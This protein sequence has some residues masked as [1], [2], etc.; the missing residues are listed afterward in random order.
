MKTLPSGAIIMDLE[1]NKPEYVNQVNEKTLEA[2][3]K[4]L[5]R[6]ALIF[7][8]E[9]IAHYNGRHGVKKT[10]RYLQYMLE[11]L[12]EFETEETKDV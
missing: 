8:E 6:R 4:F 10:R 12:E 11:Y 3:E 7:I 1:M 2:T 9:A 5:D